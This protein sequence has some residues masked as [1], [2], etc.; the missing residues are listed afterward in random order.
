M[1]FLHT[2]FKNINNIHFLQL[3]ISQ[4][5]VIV[6]KMSI[7][8]A[9]F[10]DLVC[11]TNVLRKPHNYSSHTAQPLFNYFLAQALRLIPPKMKF[12]FVLSQPKNN[13]L[14]QGLRRPL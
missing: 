13:Y 8:I 3:K 5:Q 7:N 2:D 4:G 10:V 9:Q 12:F 6:C 1:H 11:F 14:M